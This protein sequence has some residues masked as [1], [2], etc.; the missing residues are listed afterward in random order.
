MVNE[1][2]AKYDNLLELAKTEY[3]YEPP[4]DYYKDGYNLYLKMSKYKGEHLLFLHDHRVPWTNSLAERK[5]RLYKRKQ[6]QVMSFRSFE[7]LEVFC[8]TLGV[9][10]TLRDHEK[11]M[12]EA[13][14]EIFN[15][16]KKKNTA[17]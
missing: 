6:H 8:N 11:N 2:E 17:A 14:T 10:E 12:F 13:I 9:L 5:L 7:G 3:D 16:P 1:L 4:S 15:R